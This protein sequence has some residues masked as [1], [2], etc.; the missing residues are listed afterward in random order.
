MK[1]LIMRHSIREHSNGD[2]NCSINKNGIKLI[3][4]VFEEIKQYI[5]PEIIY[6][7][8][9][10]RTLDTSLIIQQNIEKHNG[11]VDCQ[12]IINKMLREVILKNLQIKDLDKPLLEIIMNDLKDD[13]D[14]NNIKYEGNNEMNSRC[15]MF[16]NKITT[17]YGNQNKDL[18]FITH[19]GV[20]NEFYKIIDSSHNYSIN[21]NNPD[22]YTPKYC[23]YFIIEYNS[24]KNKFDVLKKNF[25]TY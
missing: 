10:K 8:P 11:N 22:T 2:N 13:H 14:S 15:K 12:I 20:V 3:N 18:A 21:W 9:Y 19:G 1:I 25:E 7:S 6:S 23:G 16:L 5:I 17:I 4:K 24:E